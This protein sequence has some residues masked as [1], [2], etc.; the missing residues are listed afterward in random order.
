[1]T[2]LN[3]YSKWDKICAEKD[4]SSDDDGGEGT[5]YINDRFNQSIINSARVSTQSQSQSHEVQSQH[6][7]NKDEYE[8]KRKRVGWNKLF[9]NWDTINKEGKL[10]RGQT[11]N[12]QDL[13]NIRQENIEGKSLQGVESLLTPMECIKKY[14]SWQFSS[15]KFLSNASHFGHV[16]WLVDYNLAQEP[17]YHGTAYFMW[18]N[19]AEGGNKCV[20]SVLFLCILILINSASDQISWIFYALILY[21]SYAILL[22]D[23]YYIWPVTGHLQLIAICWIYQMFTMTFGSEI[24]YFYKCIIFLGVFLSCI[25]QG[26]FVSPLLSHVDYKS[27][28]FKQFVK[29]WMIE[30]DFFDLNKRFAK[31]NGIQGANN[32]ED[33]GGAEQYIPI[34]DN[35][36]NFVAKNKVH[37][38]KVDTSFLTRFSYVQGTFQY[39]CT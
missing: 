30:P 34:L 28:I 20:Y 3:D 5:N 39:I 29:E 11:I 4:S 6:R 24:F 38:E 12:E 1:M 13:K 37:R 21:R 23:G 36:A 26:I 35:L 22:K 10:L 9:E 32:N 14:R 27:D 8:K 15:M 25:T 31:N 33:G 18:T 19:L 2:S 16:K 17:K 7:W